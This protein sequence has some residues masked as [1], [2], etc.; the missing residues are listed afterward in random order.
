[1]TR[2]LL[3]AVMLFVSTSVS[4]QTNCAPRSVVVERLL[5]GYGEQPRTIALGANNTI[6]EQFANEETGSWT[7]IVT[8]TAGITC[9][10][11]AGEAWQLID[12]EP[13]G[14]PT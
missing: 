3:I 1:M 6:V 7:I 2:I 13:T 8:N 10:V 14:E 5:T 11:A 9:L 12:P 4:A